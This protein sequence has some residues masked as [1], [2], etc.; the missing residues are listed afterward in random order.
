MQASKLV[1]P[2]KTKLIKYP[3]CSAAAA[4]FSSYR[5]LTE[6]AGTV[7]M[8]GHPTSGVTPS[9]LSKRDVLKDLLYHF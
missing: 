6:G 1:K 5:E 2:K 9:S 8:A 4:K 7:L 3:L